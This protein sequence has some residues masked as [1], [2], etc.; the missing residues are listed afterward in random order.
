MN[1]SYKHLRDIFFALAGFTTWVFADTCMKLAGETNIPSYEVVALMGFFAA[2]TVVIMS[3]MRGRLADVLPKQPRR[4]ALRGVL[5]FGCV[6]ANTFALQHLPLTLFYVVV[7][8]S[9]LMVI[10]LAA[11]F[12]KEHLNLSMI[13]AI[14]A[15]FIGVLVAIEPW[16]HFGGGDWIGYFAATLAA[17]FYALAAVLTRN[18]SQTGTSESLVFTTAMI[19]VILGS[20]L[21]LWHAVAVPWHLLYIFVLMGSLNAIGNYFNV[22][23]LRTTSAATVEQFHYTQLIAGGVVGYLIWGDVPSLS[24]ILGAIIIILSGL[25]VAAEHHKSG[26]RLAKVEPTVIPVEP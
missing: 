12:L 3:A 16:N 17:F 10:I 26:V 24:M 2:L 9:P 23:A 25:H 21:V 15:G 1:L 11:F 20:T 6:M 18:M 14:L 8:V 19:E 7:F 22:L 4:Q 13:L 5:A